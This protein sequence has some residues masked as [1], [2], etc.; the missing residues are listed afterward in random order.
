MTKNESVNITDAMDMILRMVAAIDGVN[1][2][3]GSDL[4]A[5]R[6]EA[7]SLWN[8]WDEAENEQH[9]YEIGGICVTMTAKQAAMWNAGD[10]TKETMSGAYVSVPMRFGANSYLRN[11][12][13]V[14]NDGLPYEDTV[15]L[16]EYIGGDGD[17]KDYLEYM[18]GNEARLTR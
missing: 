3:A 17:S 5:V 14:V 10:V 11:G 2:S 9:T 15:D 18:D 16:W 8:L 6:D 1:P 12:E 7:N 4:E 13:V